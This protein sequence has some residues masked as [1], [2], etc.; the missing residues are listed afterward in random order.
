MERGEFFRKIPIEV[1]GKAGEVKTVSVS[2]SDGERLLRFSGLRLFARDTADGLGAVVLDMQI[3]GESQF[4]GKRLPTKFLH[5]VSAGR[6]TSYDVLHPRLNATLMIEFVKDCTWT[7]VWEGYAREVPNE[8]VYAIVPT[9]ACDREI[10]SELIDHE[11]NPTW[12]L[13]GLRGRRCDRCWIKFGEHAKWPWH[14]RSY[15]VELE[16]IDGGSTKDVVLQSDRLVIP[17]A[18]VVAQDKERK[19]FFWTEGFGLASG[20][21]TGP[22]QWH[23]DKFDYIVEE[24]NRLVSPGDFIFRVGNK[25][26]GPLPFA[27]KVQALEFRPGA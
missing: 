6:G 7:A 15:V 19:A 18:A 20:R 10:P 17:H 26:P 14:D 2:A 22:S 25:A 16:A 8:G 24:P 4:G 21:F 12:K 9:I 27:A 13:V 5:N 11:K 1:S 3:G 23:G